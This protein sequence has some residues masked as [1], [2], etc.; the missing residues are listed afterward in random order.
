LTNALA[1]KLIVSGVNPFK[2][3]LW[4]NSFIQFGHKNIFL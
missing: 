1:G 3:I 4:T 2:L